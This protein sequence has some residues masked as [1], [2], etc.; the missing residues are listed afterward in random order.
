VKE[1]LNTEKSS[2][3][4]NDA[5]YRTQNHSP[6]GGSNKFITMKSNGGSKLNETTMFR[7][8]KNSYAAG[9]NTS[10]T[11]GGVRFNS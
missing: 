6:A 2:A 4:N 8:K 9:E 10:R 11:P 5:F 7:S 1:H 3:K